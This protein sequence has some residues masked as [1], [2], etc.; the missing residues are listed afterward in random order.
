VTENNRK[1]RYYEI[2]ADGERH[3]K[4]E[5]ELLLRYNAAISHLLTEPA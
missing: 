3:L 4:R 1:A 5:T 2:T